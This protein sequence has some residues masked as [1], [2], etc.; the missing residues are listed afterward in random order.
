VHSLVGVVCVRD[1]AAGAL[2]RADQVAAGEHLQRLAQRRPGD[3]ELVR[4]V[5]LA[6]EEVARLQPLALDVVLDLR[7][8]LLAGAAEPGAAGRGRHRTPLPRRSITRRALPS[9][10][11]ST[12]G[13]TGTTRTRSPSCWRMTS[14]SVRAV[15]PRASSTS[16]LTSSMPP[17]SV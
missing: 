1:A 14:W 3:A 4:Q 10:R 7:R 2:A 8:D 12:P 16:S 5:L 11:G 13:P 6:A 17:G 9:V 15:A